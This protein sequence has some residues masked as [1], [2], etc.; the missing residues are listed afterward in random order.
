MGKS[1][2]SRSRVY[3]GEI[4]ISRPIPSEKRAGSFAAPKIRL[5]GSKKNLI[6]GGCQD[7]VF[8][9]GEGRGTVNASDSYKII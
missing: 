9:S 4:K 6:T 7:I 2:R 3:V 8:W 1:A 5:Q